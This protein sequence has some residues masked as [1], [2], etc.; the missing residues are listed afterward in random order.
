MADFYIHFVGKSS[1]V[2]GNVK[3]SGGK[4]EFWKQDLEDTRDEC[5]GRTNSACKWT[6]TLQVSTGVSGCGTRGQH[7]LKVPVTSPE[8]AQALRQWMA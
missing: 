3:G 6:D 2:I 1:P 5:A 8:R 4:R 7:T